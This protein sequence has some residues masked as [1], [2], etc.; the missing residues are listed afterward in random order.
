M[1]GNSV[2]ALDVF[3]TGDDVSALVKLFSYGNF[4]SITSVKSC[5]ESSVGRNL[6]D[7]VKLFIED[8]VFAACTLCE[9]RWDHFLELFIK[10]K[11]SLVDHAVLLTHLLFFLSFL[12]LIINIIIQ[13]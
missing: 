12:F 11:V 3:K 5:K 2:F 10:V 7:C 6:G 4:V 1:I 9:S 8:N 13:I